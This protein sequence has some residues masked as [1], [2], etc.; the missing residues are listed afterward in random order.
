MK[1]IIDMPQKSDMGSGWGHYEF[2]AGITL[3][4]ALDEL[5]KTLKPW[6]TITIFRDTTDVVRCFDFDLYNDKIFYHHLSGWQYN[7]TV[8][9]VLFDYCFMSENIDIYVN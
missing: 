3:R 7:Y 1:R 4:E 5:H 9:K 8:R 6:G 2:T